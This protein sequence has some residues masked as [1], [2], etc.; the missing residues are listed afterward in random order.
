MLFDQVYSIEIRC[1]LP[2]GRAARSSCR[3]RSVEGDTQTAGNRRGF[4]MGIAMGRLSYDGREIPL[5]GLAE[6]FMV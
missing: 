3:S 6:L 1:Y 5:Y 2:R 4:S